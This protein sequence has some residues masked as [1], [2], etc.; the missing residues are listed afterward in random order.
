MDN[1]FSNW[2]DYSVGYLYDLW[3]GKNNNVEVDFKKITDFNYNK[4]D[5]GLELYI[6]GPENI[7][8]NAELWLWINFQTIIEMNEK[9]PMQFPSFF[10]LLYKKIFGTGTHCIQEI[11]L[12][13]DENLL[14][15]K[16]GNEKETIKITNKEDMEN[17]VTNFIINRIKTS[18]CPIDT[19]D[20]ALIDDDGKHQ[21]LIICIK[22][23]DKYY[24]IHYEPHGNFLNKSINQFVVNIKDILQKEVNIEIEVV[25]RENKHCGWQT[26]MGDEVGW[27]VI[28]SYFWLYCILFIMKDYGNYLDI[29]FIN[30]IESIIKKIY[31][32]EE[33]ETLIFNFT[34]HLISQYHTDVK[35]LLSPKHNEEFYFIYMNMIRENFNES[36]EDADL[37]GTGN[38]TSKQFRKQIK[39]FNIQN[40]ESDNNELYDISEDDYDDNIPQ[41]KQ[42]QEAKAQEETTKQFDGQPCENG[43][44]CFSGI[45]ERRICRPWNERRNL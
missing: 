11:S 38:V 20:L 26:Y 12:N 35:V 37:I 13:T 42:I 19:F 33:F 6:P 17:F 22:L 7:K 18:N 32:P 8:V 44:D 30:N 4:F 41:Q 2:V 23:K 28:V 10:E 24:L 25:Y 14:T 31:T 5:G 16:V 29:D 43:N 1:L 27:C 9:Y 39:N 21:N 15:Y 34:Y 45:C 40:Y 36:L 3:R